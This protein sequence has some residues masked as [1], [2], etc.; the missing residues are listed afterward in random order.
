MKIKYNYENNGRA[1]PGERKLTFK[2][3]NIDNRLVSQNQKSP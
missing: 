2:N 1:D 3:L